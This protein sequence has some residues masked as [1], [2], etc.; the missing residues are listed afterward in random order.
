M[1]QNIK[2]KKK[3]LPKVDNQVNR[4]RALLLNINDNI[5]VTSSDFNISTKEFNLYF[6]VL[7]HTGYITLK[8][9]E[10]EFVSTSYVISDIDRFNKLKNNAYK[11]IPK[12]IIPVLSSIL[13]Y[14]L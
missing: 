10:K 4:I 13:P 11:L 7:Q 5:E 9:G 3:H 14:L 1:R 8:K 2:L 6:S 12:I